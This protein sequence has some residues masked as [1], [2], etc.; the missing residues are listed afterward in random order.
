MVD[1]SEK[2]EVEN[3]IRDTIK[4]LP[5]NE[6]R[7]LEEMDKNPRTTAEEL[8]Q[9]IEINLRNVKKNTDR[10]KRKGLITRVGSRKSGYWE[11]E[12]LGKKRGQATF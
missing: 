2:K 11:I 8:S 5:V 9:L 7:I 1:E 12:A 3:T 6:K 10:L 4:Q